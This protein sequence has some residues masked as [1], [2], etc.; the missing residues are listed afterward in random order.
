[1]KDNIEDLICRGYLS[2][3]IAKPNS[4]Q[5]DPPRQVANVWPSGGRQDQGSR[6]MVIHVISGDPVHGG[7]IRGAKPSLK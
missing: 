6:K 1:M 5:E 7:S 3:Y 2:Q 4:S